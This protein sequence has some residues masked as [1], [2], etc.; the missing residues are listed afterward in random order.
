MHTQRPCNSTTS[1]LELRYYKSNNQLTDTDLCS[2]M[3]PY[4]HDFVLILQLRYF[5]AMLQYDVVHVQNFISRI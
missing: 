5:K 3:P 1:L 4:I 2:S